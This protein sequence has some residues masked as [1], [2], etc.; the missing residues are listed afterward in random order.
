MCSIT[1][2]LNRCR[3]CVEDKSTG[4][5]ILNHNERPSSTGQNNFFLMQFANK[6]LKG[7]FLYMRAVHGLNGMCKTAFG[8]FSHI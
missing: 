6:I 1:L 7:I 8:A 3:I 5:H 4:R 2:H